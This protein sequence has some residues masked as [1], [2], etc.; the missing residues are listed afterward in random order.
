[1]AG[2]VEGESAGVCVE[3][4]QVLGGALYDC[5]VL[6]DELIPH[7]QRQLASAVTHLS[8]LAS[9]HSSGGLLAMHP[10]QQ[11]FPQGCHASSHRLARARASLT[12]A[13]ASH[14]GV[15]DPKPGLARSHRPKLRCG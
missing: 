5:V 4:V 12:A 6:V 2:V 3:A 7:L 1:M 9:L 11:L 13:G 15:S 8:G 10:Q 14:K